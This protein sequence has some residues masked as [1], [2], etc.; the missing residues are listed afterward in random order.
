[1][2]VIGIWAA[3]K[4]NKGQAEAFSAEV[5]DSLLKQNP[6]YIDFFP[7]ADHIPAFVVMDALTHQAA[8]MQRSK[9]DRRN[10]IAELVWL[11]AKHARYWKVGDAEIRGVIVAVLHTFS[12]HQ[13]WAPGGAKDLLAVRSLICEMVAVMCRG[14]VSD[15][16]E[17]TEV[18]ARIQDMKDKV[19]GK[20]GKQAPRKKER[21]CKMM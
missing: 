14:L 13:A 16:K 11:G 7:N 21:E 10:A 3:V 17:L 5:L 4:G 18:K 8:N 2:R 6:A 15:A 1:M 12:I 20:L 9:D 19:I